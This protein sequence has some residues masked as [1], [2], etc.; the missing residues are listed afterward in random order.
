MPKMMFFG[1]QIRMYSWAMFF[2]TLS[3]YYCY[4]ITK[5][6][7]KKNWIIFTIFSSLA[8]YTHYYGIIAVCILYSIL[9]VHLILKNKVLIKNWILST[10][11]I[12]LSYI[13]WI[14]IFLNKSFY[15]NM[16]IELLCG[17]FPTLG[18]V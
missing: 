11:F 17:L 4:K 14:I 10:T 2:L 18:G 13:P 6:S 7:T 9:L 5:K 15:I 3:F 12:S 16:L 1:L 8:I